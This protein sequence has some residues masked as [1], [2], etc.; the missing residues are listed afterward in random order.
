MEK[1][2][3]AIEAAALA[4]TFPT[5][6]GPVH[7]VRDVTFQVA[8]GEV[9]GLLGPNGAGKTTTMRMLSTLE[10]PTGGTATVAGHDLR[11]EAHR[12]REVIGLVAQSGGT[13]P[14]ATPR[15]ELVLQARV[16]RL[17]A[18]ER[19]AEESIDAFDLGAFADRPTLTLSGGQRRRV[20]LALGLVHR[21]A[22]LFLDEPTAALDPASRMELWEH[23]RTL[24]RETGATI[25]LSTHHLE[26]A[27]TLCDRI[28]LLD[29]GR[30]VTEDS[31]AR[32]KQRLGEDVITLDLGPHVA[33]GRE[34]LAGLPGIRG[35]GAHG[36]EIRIGCANADGLVTRV[37][38]AL[39][40]ADLEVRALRVEH[41]SLDD[42][43]V[44]L[45]GHA[46]HEKA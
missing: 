43:F 5:K 35:L 13:R 19:R 8:Q 27:D 44:A 40:D 16:H 45:T 14:L 37:V 15:D 4:K 36:N 11:R 22:V 10:R 12:V 38:L 30:L 18:P 7:A 31:P 34:A 23:I 17:A 1:R 41:P 24:R 28:L 42:V 6:A 46:A 20:D 26:E 21:P 2:V 29:E 3:T 33:R 25:V 9:V 39:R 32:L